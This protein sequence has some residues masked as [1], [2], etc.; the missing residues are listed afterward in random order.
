MMDAKN[1]YP[2]GFSIQF[3]HMTLLQTPLVNE[4]PRKRSTAGPIKYYYVN[5]RRSSRSEHPVTAESYDSQRDVYLLGDAF[6]NLLTEVRSERLSSRSKLVNLLTSQQPFT[7]LEFLTPLIVKMAHPYPERRPSASQALSKL[8]E[9]HRS[10][11]R[12]RKNVSPPRLF[13][14]GAVPRAE[15]E[16]TIASESVWDMAESGYRGLKELVGSL[17]N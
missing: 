16:D 1:L 4:N 6:R 5:Y 11:G 14:S 10:T 17:W 13:Q 9:L 7:G 2:E 3:S 8:K 15:E 12:V